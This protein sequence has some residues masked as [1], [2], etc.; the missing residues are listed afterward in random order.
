MPLAGLAAFVPSAE[1]GTATATGTGTGVA[2]AAPLPSVPKGV[3]WKADK[4][5]AD[6]TLAAV[7]CVSAKFCMAVGNYQNGK[8]L[9]L[10]WNGSH[11]SPSAMVEPSAGG[12][13]EPA[14]ISCVSD[15]TAPAKNFC[16]VA[17]QD[18]GLSPVNGK[19]LVATL[20]ESFEGSWRID[21][22]PNPSLFDVS[23]GTG[24]H[25]ALSAVSCASAAY[26]VA[27]GQ[28]DSA[29]AVFGASMELTMSGGSWQLADVLPAATQVGAAAC[30]L[31]GYCMVTGEP[32][33]GGT[34]YAT[35]SGPSGA[36]TQP[37]TLSGYLLGSIQCPEAASCIGYAVAGTAYSM[38]SYSGNNWTVLDLPADSGAQSNTVTS[39]TTAQDCL[40]DDNGDTTTV[41]LSAAGWNA[42][43]ASVANPT[44]DSSVILPVVSCAPGFCAAAGEGGDGKAAIAHAR[45]S[46]VA[47]G[48]SYS[49]GE[50][51]G[52][53][54]PGTAV[55]RDACH[56]SRNAYSALLARRFGFTSYTGDV[57]AKYPFA[58]CSGAVI[59]DFTRRNPAN[60]P[61][62]PQEEHLTYGA[63]GNPN[64][65]I[66]FV[67]MS[68]GGNNMM[69]P[70]V[71]RDCMLHGVIVRLAHAMGRSFIPVLRTLHRVAEGTDLYKN[72]CADTFTYG[73]VNPFGDGP[74][75]Y[76]TVSELTDSTLPQ[77]KNLYQRV[78]EDAPNASV[79][80]VGYPNFFP[81]R[82]DGDYC[83]DT[84]T[85]SDAEWASAAI[86]TF[87]EQ[88]KST[89][90][91]IGNPRLTYVAPTGTSGGWAEHSVCAADSWFVKPSLVTA[92][93]VEGLHKTAAALFDVLRLA[94]EPGWSV[95]TFFHPNAAGQRQLELSVLEQF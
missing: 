50:G 64:P 70:D 38:A 95:A 62:P 34:L 46:Y 83:S 66:D 88:L 84:V 19:P 29:T 18:A 43:G 63:G 37:Q 58:A 53:Y 30:S 51:A 11:W 42:T 41:S 87:D 40:L 89:I 5:S 61:E 90:D 71:V 45:F 23:M 48:D 21:A 74:K 47:L 6:G 14:S 86:A 76:P 36:W 24:G 72:S 10:E 91:S 81:R 22:T 94:D 78:L 32:V 35:R 44:G 17:G 4:V 27:T 49:S 20:A 59:A 60:K 73:L 55:S 2:P 82:F 54:Y 65:D 93:R 52:D 16:V 28:Y 85:K 25:N 33:S 57:G 15:P 13:A 80:V 7:S 79:M 1:A 31:S 12:V 8:L 75:N 77:L 69:F 26:C 9:A 67:T 56:R 92:L 3:P 68:L 39:C